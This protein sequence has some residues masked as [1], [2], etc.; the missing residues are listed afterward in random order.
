MREPDYTRWV[1][2]GTGLPCITR[3]L[4]VGAW[5]GYVGVPPGHPAYQQSGGSLTV[6]GYV[7]IT[8]PGERF[9]LDPEDHW[10]FGFDCG[11][12]EC[13]D[14]VPGYAH[15]A[16]TLHLPS[17]HDVNDPALTYRHLA[18]VQDECEKLAAQLGPPGWW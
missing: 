1:H 8:A 17:E 7:E 14:F 4:A 2:R 13:G 9:Q 10:W 6:H 16:R 11:H 5:A 12:S 3:R 15:M 18:Y